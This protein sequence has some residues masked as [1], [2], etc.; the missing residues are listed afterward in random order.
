MVHLQVIIGGTCALKR[1]VPLG[2]EHTMTILIV[3]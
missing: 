2:P 3:C 1:A